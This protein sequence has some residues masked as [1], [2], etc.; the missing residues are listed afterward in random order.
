MDRIDVQAGT[1]ELT[2]CGY[3]DPC[4]VEVIRYALMRWARGE[5]EQAERGAIDESFHGI[6]FTCWRRVL[7]AAMSATE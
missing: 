6:P 5:E 1:N 3:T 2:A 7:A 4:T